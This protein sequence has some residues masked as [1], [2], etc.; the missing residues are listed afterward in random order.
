MLGTV[1]AAAGPA[2]QALRALGLFAAAGAGGLPGA[3]RLDLRRQLLQ[4]LRKGGAEALELGAVAVAGEV[5]LLGKLLLGELLRGRLSRLH[6][7]DLKRAVVLQPGGRR[8]QLADDDVLLEAHEPVALALEGRIREDLGGLLEG[9]GREERLGGERRLGDPEDDPLGPGRR[10][11][12]LALQLLVDRVEDQAV[13]QLTGQQLGRAL[14]LHPD[15]LQHLA[16][17]QL[18]VLVVDV[19]ALR[20]V[21]PLDLGDDVELGLRPAVD[22]ED[23]GRIERA[24]VELVASLDSLALLHQHVRAGREGVG[25][26]L[27]LVVRD[28]ELDGLVGLFEVGDLAADLRDLGQALRL[29]RLEQLDDTRQALRDVQP[30]DTAGVAG[31]HGQLRARLADRLGGDN[32]DRVADLDQVPRRRHDAVALAADPGLGLALE[33]RTDRHNRLGVTRL[34]RLSELRDLLVVDQVAALEQLAAA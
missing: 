32:P 19:D 18:D 8:D 34:K 17:D 30:G 3:R 4:L 14:R 21:D 1:P 29:A 20:A 28:V 7:L 33:D 26:L 11:R 9:G 5:Q 10:L 6:R 16:H 24:L 12:L 31:P 23:L 2:A 25:V 15:L 13:L 27:A 22:R